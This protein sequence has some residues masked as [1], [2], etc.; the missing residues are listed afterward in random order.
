M[1]R[2]CWKVPAAA[3]ADAVTV[4][5]AAALFILAPVLALELLLHFLSMVRAR[6]R[7]DVDSIWKFAALLRG[8][9]AGRP[10]VLSDA[11][12]LRTTNGTHMEVQ[13]QCGI[14]AK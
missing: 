10:L 7:T 11:E 9:N 1:T 5:A 12:G 2:P 8:V 6:R 3:A 14:A 4:D 13:R